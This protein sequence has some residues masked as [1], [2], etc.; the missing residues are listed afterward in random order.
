MIGC[1]YSCSGSSAAGAESDRP[2]SRV[3]EPLTLLISIAA[4]RGREPAHHND[5]EFLPETR[6]EGLDDQCNGGR[7]PSVAIPIRRC[8]M[9]AAQVGGLPG[10]RLIRLL[11]CLKYWHITVE[12][13]YGSFIRRQ[14]PCDRRRGLRDAPALPPETGAL[15]A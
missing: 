9:K 2:L 7:A 3:N 4:L 5:I 11:T 8:G 15:N 14:R 6:V 10:V 13:E 12:S 1:S